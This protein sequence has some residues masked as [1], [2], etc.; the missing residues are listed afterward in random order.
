VDY[1]F[2]GTPTP[3]VDPI[4]PALQAYLDELKREESVP[5]DASRFARRREYLLHDL[6]LGLQHHAVNVKTEMCQALIA[7]TTSKREYEDL[8]A[9]YDDEL[10]RYAEGWVAQKD[11]LLAT[12]ESEALAD[13]LHHEANRVVY[14]LWPYDPEKETIGDGVRQPLP[15]ERPGTLVGVRAEEGE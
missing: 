9:R 2:E 11:R 5:W 3:D 4:D 12:L 15:R 7:A 8:V 10:H 14:P 6:G 13:K 1:P